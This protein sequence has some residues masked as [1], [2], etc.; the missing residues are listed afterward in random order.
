M[1]SLMIVF[2]M[3]MAAGT[4]LSGQSATQILEELI[5]QFN[6]GGANNDI[7]KISPVL[8]DNFRVVFKNTVENQVQILDRA[9][10][11]DL[12]DKKVFGGEARKV[13]IES[14]Q[15]DDGMMASV[16][17]QQQGTKNTLHALKNF[18]FQDGK[19]LMTEEVV[20]MK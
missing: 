13:I 4:S 7:S 19:W 16:R 14:L 9:T 10:Y 8:H 20:Y 6:D 18:V 15:I 11:L 1:K 12:I 17:T 5:H 2:S 3:L